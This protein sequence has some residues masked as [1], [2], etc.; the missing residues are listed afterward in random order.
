M[1]QLAFIVFEIASHNVLLS[2]RS[3]RQYV[4]L[5]MKNSYPLLLTPLNLITLQ[6]A[7]AMEYLLYEYFEQIYPLSVE[8]V[9]LTVSKCSW[10]VQWTD[11]WLSSIVVRPN[12]E[13]AKQLQIS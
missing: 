8:W 3:A 11:S 7:L 13:I 4:S 5:H 12:V 6:L 10:A 2:V 9:D 1:T